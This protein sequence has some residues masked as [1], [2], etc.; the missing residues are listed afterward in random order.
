MADPDQHLECFVVSSI[1]DSIGDL[2]IGRGFK[3]LL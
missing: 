2:T 3:A 1:D